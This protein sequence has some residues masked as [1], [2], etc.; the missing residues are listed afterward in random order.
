VEV[1]NGYAWHILEGKGKARINHIQVMYGLFW[2][3]EVK[4]GKEKFIYPLRLFN[5]MI[6]KYDS[7]VK[8]GIINL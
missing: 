7:V 5:P 8:G 2:W 1:R 3:S 6:M 4:Q